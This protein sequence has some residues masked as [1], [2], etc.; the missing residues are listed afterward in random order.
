MLLEDGEETVP[1]LAVLPRVVSVVLELLELFE[2][3]RTC[4]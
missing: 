2:Q 3:K 4:C 1:V